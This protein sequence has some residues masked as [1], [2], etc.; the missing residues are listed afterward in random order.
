MYFVEAAVPPPLPSLSPCPLPCVAFGCPAGLPRGLPTALS[1]AQL[2]R[3]LPAAAFTSELTNP[4]QGTKQKLGSPCSPAHPG[5]EAFPE[6]IHGCMQQPGAILHPAPENPLCC[7]PALRR[8]MINL[9]PL[10]LLF[11]YFVFSSSLHPQP[12]GSS[13]AAAAPSA[14]LARCHAHCKRDSPAPGWHSSRN[15]SAPSSP[16]QLGH[17][18]TGS[19][20][21]ICIEEQNK[22]CL[23]ELQ[24]PQI[25]CTATCGARAWRS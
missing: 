18:Q 8:G 14:S 20:D 22:V 23:Q 3:L 21:R 17:P 6:L 7:A 13:Q 19:R 5:H 10:S 12:C 1:P 2:T 9:F 4:P 16:A 15:S 11:L 24:Q 25:L